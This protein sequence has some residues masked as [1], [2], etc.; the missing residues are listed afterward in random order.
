MKEEEIWKLVGDIDFEQEKIKD[1]EKLHKLK[2]IDFS[3]CT[4]RNFS[5]EYLVQT[6]EVEEIDLGNNFEFKM[7]KGDCYNRMFYNCTSLEKLNL[8]NIDTVLKT[9][10]LYRIFENT[11]LAVKI[12]HK[13]KFTPTYEFDDE[14]KLLKTQINNEFIPNTPNQFGYLFHKTQSIET[15]MKIVY[16]ILKIPNNKTIDT[17]IIKTLTYSSPEELEKIK[18]KQSLLDIEYLDLVVGLVY[19][20]RDYNQF[21]VVQEER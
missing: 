14:I 3:N 10:E 6:L 17:S 16:K 1:K 15:L 12:K 18:L 19:F 4:L 11:N 7:D 13:G 2:K 5:R 9:T 20:N 21:L 8:G